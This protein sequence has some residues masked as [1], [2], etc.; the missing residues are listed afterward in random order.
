MCQ[1]SKTFRSTSELKNHQKEIH[2]WNAPANW[3]VQRISER[4]IVHIKDTS[5]NM[6][7]RSR[8]DA[9]ILTQSSEKKSTEI[10]KIPISSLGTVERNTISIPFFHQFCI[11]NLL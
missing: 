10:A 7:K 2:G 6:E 9:V 8:L 1:G 5:Q 3:T 11:S 4:T